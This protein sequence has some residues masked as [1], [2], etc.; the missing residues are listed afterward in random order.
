[1]SQALH[2]YLLSELGLS[3]LSDMPPYSLRLQSHLPISLPLKCLKARRKIHR[4]KAKLN[5]LYSSSDIR[6]EGRFLAT[7]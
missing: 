4:S 1:M 6:R 5:A 2:A 7:V 3:E